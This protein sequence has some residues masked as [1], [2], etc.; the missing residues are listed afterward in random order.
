M[1]ASMIRFISFRRAAV[2]LTLVLS[3]AGL[4]GCAN[5]G[6]GPLSGAFVDPSIYDYY[7]CKQLETQRKSLT[8]RATQ[9]QAL[10]D[11]ADTGFGGAIVGEVAYRNDY[12][13]A[14]AQLKLLEENWRRNKCKA[15]P[16]DPTATPA[17]DQPP[18]KQ[19]RPHSAARSIE[20]VH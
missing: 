10:I 9:L 6:D 4:S 16:P 20:A 5:M 12:I 19:K 3:G 11:K 15:L 1:T 17:A 2:A 13:T 14:R 8:D 18:L 7:D